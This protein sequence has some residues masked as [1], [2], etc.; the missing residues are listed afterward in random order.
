[1][2]NGTCVTNAFFFGGGGWI[3]SW[4]F[5]INGSQVLP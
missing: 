5:F 4:M 1:M 2:V 3:D